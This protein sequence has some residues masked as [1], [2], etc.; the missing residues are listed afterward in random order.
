[1]GHHHTPV[2]VDP[3]QLD[4][5]QRLWNNF[6]AISK[7]SIVGIVIVLALMTLAFIG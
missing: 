1:M 3:Q 2:S 4:H 6:I 7:W 5:A